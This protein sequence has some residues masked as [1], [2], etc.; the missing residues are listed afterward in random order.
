MQALILVRAQDTVLLF[1]SHFWH[2]MCIL[3]VRTR[4]YASKPASA[5]S[6]SGA[7][8]KL[9]AAARLAYPKNS[10]WSAV[11]IGMDSKR[12]PSTDTWRLQGFPDEFHLGTLDSLVAAFSQLQASRSF[13][14]EPARVFSTASVRLHGNLI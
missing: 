11:Y 13:A 8:A 7:I 14:L 3:A 12:K 9:A 4:S 10:S 6:Y 5:V 1:C 2:S